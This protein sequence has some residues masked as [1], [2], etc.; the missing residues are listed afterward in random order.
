VEK[1]YGLPHLVRYL[2]QLLKTSMKYDIEK[3][4]AKELAEQA[5]RK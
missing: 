2:E 4:V 5:I 1:L 3:Q